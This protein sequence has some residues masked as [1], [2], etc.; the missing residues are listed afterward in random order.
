MKKHQTW[1]A[2]TLLFAGWFQPTYSSAAPD[3]KPNILLIVADDLG[4]SDLGAFGS[5]NQ[6]P[7]IDQL[8]K[9]GR[10][11]RRFYTQPTCSPTRS[12][13]LSGTDHHLAGVGSMLTSVGFSPY[14]PSVQI[15]KVGPL[16]S[17]KLGHPSGRPGLTGRS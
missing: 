12:E 16:I 14:A 13:L 11:L 3:K 7:N 1:L 9:R 4:Y 8:A 17:V 2:L 15:A 5:E 10:I 6:T